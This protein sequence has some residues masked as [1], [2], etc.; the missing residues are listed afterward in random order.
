[1][2]L[3]KLSTCIVFLSMLLPI[4]AYPQTGLYELQKGRM[5][6]GF[7]FTGL[8]FSSSQD[9]MGIGGSL[10]YGIN[11]RTKIA[12]TT[13][14]GF[15][16]RDRYGSEFDVPPPV[17][18]G[19]GAM[20]VRPL[21]QVG[22][23]YFVRGTLYTGFSNGISRRLDDPTNKTLLSVRSNGFAGGVGILKRLETNIGWTLNPS[24]SLSYSRSWSRI[25]R[26]AEGTEDTEYNRVFSGYA[27]GLGLEVEFSPMISII[28]TFGISLEN[29]D[30]SFSIGLNLH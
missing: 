5:A 4:T 14:M 15:I 25:Y 24:C 2:H 19:I 17:A 7:G 3:K 18:I 8:D 26:K 29:F 20:H 30:K 23:D 22:I 13:N 27:G 12:L 6:V 11:N 16:D 1:M 28:G 9:A 10:S 21:G